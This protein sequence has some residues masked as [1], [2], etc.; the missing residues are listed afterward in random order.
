MIVSVT[1]KR[2][3]EKRKR[4]AQIMRTAAALHT[5]S[6]R[7]AGTRA[8]RVRSASART[9]LKKAAL[10]SACLV[11]S[12]MNGIAGNIPEMAAAFPAVPLQ[13]VELITTVPALF[14][15][16]G[17]LASGALS[18]R[19]GTKRALLSGIALC[20]AAGSLPFFI[21]SFV[22]LLVTRCLF[23][24][25]Q[26]TVVSMTMAMIAGLY[27]GNE[28]SDMIG[29][30]GSINGLGSALAAWVGGQLLVFGWQR[31]FAVY[32]TGAAVLPLVA[33]FV[34]D[35]PSRTASSDEKTACTGASAPAAQGSILPLAGW[36]AMMFVS[37]LCLSL[38]TV[39]ASQLIASSG[40]GT[41][42]EGSTAIAVISLGAVV[43]GALF[44]RIHSALRGRD[45]AVYYA[46]A[47]AGFI[48]A[49][50]SRSMA[51]TLAGSLLAGF[52][53]MGF[54]P[55]LQD[56]A[57]KC[58]SGMRTGRSGLVLAAQ[59]MGSFASPWLGALL[60]R[61]TGDLRA[62]FLMAGGVFLALAGAAAMLLRPRG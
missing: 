6:P 28:R 35:T 18:R 12:S 30:N 1:E 15:M 13:A 20:A 48:L 23:G 53:Y 54:I 31:S 7:I 47:A 60:A 9:Y 3:E 17:I 50:L 25:G 51:V 27:D 8:A 22:L 57:A 37:V 36:S 59:S 11:S 29:M 42:R 44:G 14:A 62:Q 4:K 41:A 2:E 52:G 19:T 43:S 61:F 49:G 5:N 16:A 32:F 21:R 33:L 40:L 38:F 26:G 58:V 45:L 24:L 55:Y 10:L 56:R 39:K 46:A 34:P